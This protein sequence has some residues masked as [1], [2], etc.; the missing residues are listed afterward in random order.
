MIQQLHITYSNF[1]WHKITTA[2]MLLLSVVL[3]YRLAD[4]FPPRLWLFL[5]QVLP[6]LP[7]LWQMRGIAL[8]PP[9]LGLLLLS[10]S[11]FLLWSLLISILIRTGLHWWQEHQE[12]QRLNQEIAE[13]Q[14]LQEL[15]AQQEQ[16]AADL[17]ISEAE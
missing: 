7:L 6:T 16:Q 3:L 14:E 2:I 15:Q 13:L 11:L 12:L 17:P 4:G 9:L 10:F 8:V 1:R 5:L